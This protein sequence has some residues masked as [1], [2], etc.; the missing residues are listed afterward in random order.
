MAVNRL[1]LISDAAGDYNQAHNKRELKLAE[2]I[3]YNKNIV[4]T[5]ECSP[6]VSEASNAA[7]LVH[8]DEAAD[9]SVIGFMTA[10]AAYELYYAA[11]ESAGTAVYAHPWVSADGLEVPQDANHIDGPSAVEIT[12]GTTARSQ[13]KFTVGTDPDFYCEATIKIDD[14]SDVTSLMFGFRKAEAYRANPEDYDEAAFWQIGG[15][16]DGQFNIWTILANAATTKT[17]T[18][19]TDWADADEFTLRVTVKKN[20]VTTF[21]VNGAA[22]TVTQTFT[23]A[24]A[25]VVLPFLHLDGETG[26]AGVSIASWKC[27]RY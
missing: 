22:P 15:T 13:A 18:T 8:P 23:F 26:N 1:G 11:V 2:T 3:T 16:T 25:E 17:D 10:K 4:D 21:S 9:A 19:L 6:V 14:I 5:F 27:G 20:G 7:G 12:N 24:A